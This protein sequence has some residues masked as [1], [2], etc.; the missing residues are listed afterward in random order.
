MIAANKTQILQFFADLDQEARGIPTRDVGYVTY[1]DGMAWHKWA[2]SAINLLAGVIGPDSVHTSNLHRIY[3]KSRGYANE[4]R[5]AYGVFL[6]AKADVESGALFRIESLVSGEILSDFLALAKEALSQGSKDVAAVLACAALEDALKR[7]AV[8]NGLDI[9]D[10]NM[11]EVVGAL[12][13]KGLVSGAQKSLLDT[14]PKIRDYAMH[15]NWDKIT[16]PD[17]SSVIGYVENFLLVHFS[18]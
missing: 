12:K 14:M 1:V 9:T 4:F 2:T 7:Y 15:A 16:S 8:A 3:E 6:A 17:V 18:S 5:A 10:R 11:Q 13:A